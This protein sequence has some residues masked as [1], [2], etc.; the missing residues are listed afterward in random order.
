M[1]KQLRLAPSKS[2]ITKYNKLKISNSSFKQDKNQEK[3][4]SSFW[5]ILAQIYWVKQLLLLLLKNLLGE[6]DGVI[7]L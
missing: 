3:L 5:D 2:G 4:A 7:L 1:N 6:N